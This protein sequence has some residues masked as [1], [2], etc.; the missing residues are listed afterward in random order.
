MINLILN[1][2]L[3][4][5]I[6]LLALS[7]QFLLLRVTLVE[8][9]CHF[10]YLFF[11]GYFLNKNCF[12]NLEIILFI[13]SGLPFQRKIRNKDSRRKKVRKRI[14]IRD[15][16]TKQKLIIITRQAKNN[17]HALR[18][19][20]KLMSNSHSACKQWKFCFFSRFFYLFIPFFSPI[21]I[22]SL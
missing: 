5:S 1:R 4:V 12:F 7:F 6:E 2:H 11:S 22:S 10:L 21:N 3:F 16:A 9:L 19:A 20:G 18:S 8:N 13:H 15:T 17:K 14:Q